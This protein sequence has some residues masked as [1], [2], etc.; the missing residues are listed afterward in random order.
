MLWLFAL[1]SAPA[2]AAPD[3][4]AVVTSDD[5]PVY[6]EPVRAFLEELEDVATVRVIH[7]RGRASEAESA[8]L[9]LRREDPELIF[10][11]GA[12]AAFTAKGSLPSTPLIHA[13]ISDPERYGI[14]GNQVTGV[15]LEAAPSMYL[16]QLT[17]LFPDLRRVGILHGS[18]ASKP[19][20]GR[21]EA[22]AGE[23]G[24][25]ASTSSADSPRAL[26]KALPELLEQVDALWLVPD[27][28]V[29]TPDLFRTVVDES[30]RRG[31]PLLVDS[32]NMVRAGGLFSV[33]ADPDAVGRQ[34][35]EMAE[36]ILAGKAPSLIEIE[37]PG[38]TLVVLNLSAL[39]ASGLAIDPLLLDFV[40]L[41]VD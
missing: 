21:I 3:S 40:D 38:A 37:D 12:K 26:R 25:T 18:G 29:L 15:R 41:K 33:V 9:L 39:D 34:A 30:R 28:E 6:T 4:I 1:F 17:G 27:R 22:A 16:S 35:A 24:L 20:I 14:A 31:V 10:A 11:I 8:S 23:L 2:M 13:S 36:A 7:L 32:H 5:F 19:R